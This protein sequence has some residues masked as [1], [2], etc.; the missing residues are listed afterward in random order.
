VYIVLRNIKSLYLRLLTNA[1]LLLVD[2][3]R[4]RELICSMPSC[5]TA[6]F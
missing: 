3:A 5:G 1:V 2:E 4:K 6:G